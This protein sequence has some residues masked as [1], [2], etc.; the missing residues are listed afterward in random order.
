MRPAVSFAIFRS[1]KPGILLESDSIWARVSLI[2]RS[3]GPVLSNGRFAVDSCETM[4]C[5]VFSCRS[6]GCKSDCS[7]MGSVFPSRSVT[8]VKISSISC[9]LFRTIM[10]QSPSA[11]RC[12]IRLLR[13]TT[14]K[15]FQSRDRWGRSTD[16]DRSSAT[17]MIVAERFARN[18]EEFGTGSGGGDESIRSVLM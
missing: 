13:I 5:G 12:S 10:A 11:I 16:P 1:A 8:V 9:G 14:G 4:L 3:I 2:F 6:S 18:D 17:A 15:V 7:T